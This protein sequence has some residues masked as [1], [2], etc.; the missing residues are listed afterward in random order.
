MSWWRSK[1][2]A[3]VAAPPREQLLEVA[4]RVAVAC[5]WPWLEPVAIDVESAAAEGRT[6]SVRTNCQQRG[7]N[8][9]IV[10]RESDL[11]VVRAGFLPR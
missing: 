4:Q 6:W 3:A 2:P 8:V 9:V 1:K 7:M 5:G 10:I 11:R